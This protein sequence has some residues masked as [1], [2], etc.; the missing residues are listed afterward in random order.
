MR[1]FKAR[2][3]PGRNY[4]MRFERGQG[5]VRCE[6]F[7]PTRSVNEVITEILELDTES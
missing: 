4:G 3:A 2:L 6:A 1:C 7:K 5:F